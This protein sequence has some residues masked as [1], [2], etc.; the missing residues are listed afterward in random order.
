MPR[1]R[2]WFLS[3]DPNADVLPDV[4]SN[5]DRSDFEAAVESA[6]EHIAAGDVFQLVPVRGWR[7]RC[8]SHPWSCTGAC[9]W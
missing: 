4:S 3:M 1:Y 2:R 9:G 8:P 5:R 7:H 6:R